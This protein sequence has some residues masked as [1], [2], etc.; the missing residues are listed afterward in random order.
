MCEKTTTSAHMKLKNSPAVNKPFRSL[1]NNN[2]DVTPKRKSNI[3]SSEKVN[4]SQVDTTK[5]KLS[6]EL[7]F[8]KK[9]RLDVEEEDVKNVKIDE[10]I[11]VFP[12]DLEEL[13][14]RIIKKQKNIEILKNEISYCKKNNS[15]DLEA[16]IKQWRFA[17]QDALERL[18]KDLESKRGQV[19]TM[20]EI[21]STL[22]IP[23]TLVNY[24][25]ENDMFIK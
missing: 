21:L 19:M 16:D 13:E 23:K 3:E 18:Q 5:R 4:K 17:C 1:F 15:T 7:I 12:N 20:E 9:I 8:T 11:N 14:K 24:S 2:H 25:T 10:S 6:R 22:G